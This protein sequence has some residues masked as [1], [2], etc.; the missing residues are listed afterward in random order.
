MKQFSSVNVYDAAVQRMI[1]VY[2]AGHRV[3]VA[4]SAGKDSNAVL[5]IAI[6]AARQTGN[7]PVEVW[8]RDEEIMYPGTFE[9][10]ER[11][12]NR[13][14]VNMHWLIAGQ[15]IVNIFNRK[16]PYY[17]VFDKRLDSNEWM[18]KPP[19]F[20]RYVQSLNIE[21]II[22]P[23]DFPPPPDKFL[24]VVLGVRGSESRKRNMIIHQSGGATSGSHHKLEKHFRPIYDWS[25][26]DV[27]LAIK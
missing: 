6:D 18:R 15:P 25:T 1:E 11:V 17:W 9:Y 20:A 16:E 3:I 23:V 8:M 2:K 13:K 5:E 19:E 12:A 4:F 24:Y 14:E 21:D 22:N 26:K 27:W 7:L 10:A